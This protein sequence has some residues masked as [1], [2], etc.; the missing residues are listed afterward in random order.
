MAL[1]SCFPQTAIPDPVTCDGICEL[2][3]PDDCTTT[4]ISDAIAFGVDPPFLYVTFTGSISGDPVDG[5]S[6]TVD[7]SSFEFSN[8]LITDDIIRYN[9][10]YIPN[11]SLVYYVYD[12]TGNITVDGSALPAITYPVSVVN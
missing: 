7:G 11:E 5:A 6:Y 8:S 3:P 10:N 1:N 12:G 9:T 4:Y 2:G